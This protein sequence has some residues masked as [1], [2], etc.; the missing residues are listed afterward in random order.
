MSEG[1]E[2]ER[3]RICGTQSPATRRTDGELHQQIAHGGETLHG[4]E[5]GSPINPSIGIKGALG[6][7]Y[8]MIVLWLAPLKELP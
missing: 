5:S 8:V 3:R 6:E 2:N 1:T 4:H 7:V